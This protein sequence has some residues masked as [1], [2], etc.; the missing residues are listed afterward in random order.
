M[1]RKKLTAAASR[2]YKA[3]LTAALEAGFAVL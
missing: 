3:A 1:P 2:R